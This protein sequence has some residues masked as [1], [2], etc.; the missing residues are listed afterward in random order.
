MDKPSTK[1]KTGNPGKP[2]GS[3][4]KTTTAAKELFYEIMDGEIGNIKESLDQVRR[5]N[6]A[7][8]LM[9]LSKLMPYF[10]PKKLEVETPTE[11]IINVKRRG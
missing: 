6:P 5:K 9:T 3:K 1:F 10:L 2:K 7:M 4:N 11:M 8:Y